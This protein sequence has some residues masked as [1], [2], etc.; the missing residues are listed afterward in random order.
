MGTLK[1]NFTRSI[2]LIIQLFPLLTFRKLYQEMFK[3]RATKVQNV[4]LFSRGLSS[5]QMVWEIW[6]KLQHPKPLVQTLGG[7]NEASTLK[8]EAKLQRSNE[9]KRENGVIINEEKE[10]MGLLLIR[11]RENG[12]INEEKEGN[13]MGFACFH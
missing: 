8:R 10:K 9:E 2:N 7:K 6:R 4:F 11:E 5:E 12:V 1:N 3:L 13:V